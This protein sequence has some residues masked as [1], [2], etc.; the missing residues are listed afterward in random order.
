MNQSEHNGGR[1][2][3]P[4][5]GIAGMGVKGVLQEWFCPRC[6]FFDSL[7]G[8]ELLPGD[9]RERQSAAVG[10]L[11]KTLIT[12]V[13]EPAPHP[14]RRPVRPPSAGNETTFEAAYS[15]RVGR[16]PE[17]E[18]APSTPGARYPAFEGD[19]ST[20]GGRY[21]VFEGIHSTPGGRYSTFEG[22]H[23]T[24]G[25]KCPAFAGEHPRYRRVS[26]NKQ[27]NVKHITYHI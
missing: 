17:F 16:Y 20:P 9:N 5:P 22:G 26:S 14:P 8:G 19:R 18:G 10:D 21:P 25:G 1:G 23:S 11:N 3:R 2:S 6:G 24:P 7:R 12:L 4:G 13:K 15:T 27:V